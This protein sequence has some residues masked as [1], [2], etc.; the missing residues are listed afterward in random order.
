MGCNFYGG[1][2]VKK[3]HLELLQEFDGC[4]GGDPGSPTKRSIWLFGIEFGFP[5]NYQELAGKH[6]TGDDSYSISI[7][8]QF[9]YNR[10]AFK[11]LAVAHGFQLDE[12]IAF[13]NQYQPFVKDGKGFFLGNLYPYP[14]RNVKDWPDYAVKETGFQ[15]KKEYQ[16]WCGQHR[17][18][19][20]KE[21]VDKYLPTIFIGVGNTWRMDFSMAVFGKPVNLEKVEWK[22]ETGQTK[23]LYHAREGKLKLV[24]IPH[25]SNGSNGLNSDASLEWAGSFIREM[26]ERE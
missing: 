3:E 1:N 26:L 20:I 23:R 18:P 9:P 22:S 11:L 16:D 12:Y 24:V 10:N 4:A 2:H 7:Q 5:V 21:W 6:T 25:L 17:L 14:C 15:N 8:Q 19:T 13:T